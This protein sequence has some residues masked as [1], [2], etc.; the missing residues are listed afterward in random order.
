MSYFYIS[1]VK[2]ISD[3][4]ND[5]IINFT[6]GCNLICGK[7]NSGKTMIIRTIDWLFGADYD[8]GKGLPFLPDKTGYHTAELTLTTKNGK[9]IMRR[10]AEKGAKLIVESTDSI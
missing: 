8:K 7:S 1:Q 10:A 2:A 3:V 9:I 4:K 5:A 6:P